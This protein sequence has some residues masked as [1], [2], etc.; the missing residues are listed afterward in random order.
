M[1]ILFPLWWMNSNISSRVGSKRDLFS[2]KIFPFSLKNRS[3]LTGVAGVH[4]SFLTNLAR[5]GKLEQCLSP[6]KIFFVSRRLL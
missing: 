6:K 2:S 1:S 3:L 5:Q 4:N